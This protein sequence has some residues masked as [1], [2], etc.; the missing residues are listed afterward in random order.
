MKFCR[1]GHDATL[2]FRQGSECHLCMCTGVRRSWLARVMLWWLLVGAGDYP[3]EAARAFLPVP[4]ASTVH[5]L[6]VPATK[7]L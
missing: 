7:T 6:I 3:A 2:H 1:C 4:A 5:R